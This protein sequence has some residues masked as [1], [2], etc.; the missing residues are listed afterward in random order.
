MNAQVEADKRYLTNNPEAKRR[1]QIS[2]FRSTCKRYIRE[3][4]TNEELSELEEL[5]RERK[6]LGN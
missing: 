6:S 4:A 5:I 2:A 3:F 1:K